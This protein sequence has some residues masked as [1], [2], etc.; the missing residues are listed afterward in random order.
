MKEQET[1]R[2]LAP[3]LNQQNVKTGTPSF[4]FNHLGTRGCTG[5]AYIQPSTWYLQI[6]LLAKNIRQRGRDRHKI[7]VGWQ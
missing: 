7:Y 6:T 5:T 4:D 3:F 1:N 2:S